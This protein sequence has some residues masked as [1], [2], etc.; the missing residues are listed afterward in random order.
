MCQV[1]VRLAQSPELLTIK[2]LQEQLA[3]RGL[4]TKGKKSELTVRI[5]EAMAPRTA[6]EAAA[7]KAIAGEHCAVEHVAELSRTQTRKARRNKRLHGLA[8]EQPHTT[9]GKRAK[10]EFE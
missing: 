10:L 9:G 6:E 4:P 3:I 5:A 1:L 8:I 2:E 7:E